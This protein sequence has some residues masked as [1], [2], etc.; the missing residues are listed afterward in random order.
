MIHLIIGKQG[1]GKTLILVRH[2]YDSY[3]NGKNVYSNVHLSFKSKADP[4]DKKY[5]VKPFDKWLKAHPDYKVIKKNIDDDDDLFY[6]V[7]EEYNNYA[8]VIK[9]AFHKEF[10]YYKL[11]LDDILNCRLSN[12]LVIL[13]EIHLYLP[14]RASLSKV[15]RL[16]CDSFLSMVR[17]KRLIVMGTTQTER[18]VDVRF[19]EEKDYFWNVKKY[20][21]VNKEWQEILHNQNLPA[22]IPLMIYTEVQ[23]V[24]SGSTVRTN[25]IA[26]ELFNIYDTEQVIK[27][28]GM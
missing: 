27:I 16:I 4:N 9:K 2:A 19:R 21:F 23:E 18:K 13:D 15:N 5:R 20:G 14:A 8:D 28:E 22:T 25:F 3:L 6:H 7:N 11:Y 12:G 10:G 26:N 1:S 17:K 24:F